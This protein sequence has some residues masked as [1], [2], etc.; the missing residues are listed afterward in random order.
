MPTEATLGLVPR[1]GLVR[2]S[3]E[4]PLGAVR[5]VHD[6]GG[7]HERGS[8]RRELEWRAMGSLLDVSAIERERERG[9]RA[10]VVGACT[11]GGRST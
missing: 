11:L 9:W 8:D 5:G 3:G 7:D 4:E 1:R 10:G 6:Y 2:R